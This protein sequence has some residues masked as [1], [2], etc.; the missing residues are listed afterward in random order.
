MRAQYSDKISKA[1]KA[2]KSNQEQQMPG[3]KHSILKNGLDAIKGHDAGLLHRRSSGK[4]M[5]ALRHAG[6]NQQST[7]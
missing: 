1:V 4:W 3:N 6:I 5:H 7:Q 2:A